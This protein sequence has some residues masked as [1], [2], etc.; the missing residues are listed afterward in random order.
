LRWWVRLAPRPRR[1]L[2]ARGGHPLPGR[3]TTDSQWQSEV[4]WPGR[5]WLGESG[6]KGWGFVARKSRRREGC[7]LRERK[8]ERCRKV[9][10]G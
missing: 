1:R 8:R 9:G 10:G 4:P 7:R 2:R 5:E 6:R 3:S